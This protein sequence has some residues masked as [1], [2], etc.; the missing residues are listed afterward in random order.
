MAGADLES[1]F[2]CALV[3]SSIWPKIGKTG[4]AAAAAAAPVKQTTPVTFLSCT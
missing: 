4:A 2:V 1:Q 3:C